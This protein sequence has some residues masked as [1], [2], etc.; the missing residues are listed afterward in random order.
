MGIVIKQGIKSTIVSYIGIV[1]GTFNVLWLYPMFLEP[2]TIGLLRVLQDLPL[3]I[4]LFVQMGATSIIDKFF[5][6]FQ[7][8]KKNT[9]GFLFLVLFY[10]F[11]CFII[12]FVMFILGQETWKSVF[13]V[14]SPLVSDFFIYILPLVAFM[15]Y[16]YILE[17]YLR[18]YSKVVFPTF[19]R[20]VLIRLVLTLIVILYS[21]RILSLN[22]S[23][24]S[25]TVMY[26]L[27]PVILFIYLY[28]LDIL[29]L[30]PKLKHLNKP[31]LKEM[32]IYLFFAI[33][34]TAGG[35]IVY[36]LD[37][38][39]LGLMNGLEQVAIYSIAYFIGTIVEIPKRSISQASIP[40]LSNA[41]KE[42]NFE[43]INSLY[44]KTAL[45]QLL[46]GIL[47]FIAIWLNVDDIFNLI[48]H[49]K[50]YIAGKYVILFVGFAKL[51]DMATSINGEIIIFSK[52][53]RFN[54]FST[55]ALAILTITTN[56]I[57]IPIYK[58]V[59]AAIAFAITI[60]LFNTLRSYYVW[61]R[62]SI[63]PLSLEMIYL[64]CFLVIMLTGNYFIK[65]NQHSILESVFYIVIKC[66]VISTIY[67]FMIRKFKI[68]TDLNGL[69]DRILKRYNIKL[70][71]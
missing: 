26:G 3:L 64:I 40:I 18:A 15:M 69:I 71:I 9:N 44:K 65:P 4:A 57:L 42:E 54:L 68:S 29:D 5:F 36:K 47:I 13:N 56:V 43:M 37:S 30:R 10:P 31:L 27:S 12:F 63:H 19:I 61:W 66:V 11:V 34:G 39:M 28:K 35:I 16:T 22:D 20:E 25:L 8:E 70:N 60:V 53:F 6:Y 21:Q 33:S 14:K 59:G 51:A 67:F 62:M 50:N 46:A 2:E 41:F 55:I 49:S 1:I 32:G 52:Y 48:P 7:E 24:L 58:E 38:V 23:I 45:N 17:A